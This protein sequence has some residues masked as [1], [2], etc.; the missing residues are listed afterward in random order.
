LLLAEGIETSAALAFAH[1]IEIEASNIVV[2]AALSASGIRGF[3]PWPATR[4][5]TIAADRDENKPKEERGFKA[6]EHAANAFALHRHE[7]LEVGI[8]LPGE[9]GQDFDW[10]DVLRSAGPEAV[11]AGIARAERFEPSADEAGP[12][13]FD[14]HG[15]RE[16][17]SIEAA[18]REIVA[19][20]NTDTSAP[21]EPEA[22]ATI[23]AVRQN[24]PACYQ[25]ILNQLKQAGIRMRDFE[26]ELRRASF[27]V[28]EGGPATAATDPAV[29]A[30]P[31]F[32]T[33]GLIAW[34]KETREGVVLQP[35]CNFTGRI[36][37]EEVLDDGA[38]RRTI[39]AI[40]GVMPD[41]RVL[42]CTRV[43]AERYWAMSWVTEAW[44]T[45]PVIFA[46]QG[47]KDHLRAAIQMLSG[48]QSDGLRPSWLA[49]DR[50]SMGVPPLRRRHRFRGG[51]RRHR[52]RHR[53]RQPPGL[54]DP[55]SADRR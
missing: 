4:R 5:V 19:R 49:P 39:L 35:L 22:L 11:R 30:G 2:A 25:R 29:A 41:G 48:A 31:Y 16:R 50:R 47:K 33:H 53:H 3:G 42:P 13:T 24:D 38:E 45:A 7:R 28:I 36:V 51:A 21:F 20:A 37:A 43:L 9:P 52:G 26:R 14:A 27:R 54:P 34:R 23:A 10:L 55:R 44:G 6:G 12:P 8:A 17:D 15:E 1:R 40:E 18:L 46:G 32:E